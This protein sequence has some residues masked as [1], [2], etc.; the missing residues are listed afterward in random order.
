[1]DNIKIVL[2]VGCFVFYVLYLVTMSD[3]F[4]FY[5]LKPHPV[6][7]ILYIIKVSFYLGLV[8]Y[9]LLR[10]GSLIMWMGWKSII[11]VVVFYVCG[12]FVINKWVLMPSVKNILKMWVTNLIWL[13]FLLSWDVLPMG[14]VFK[15]VILVVFG[16]LYVIS[17]CC[18]W[19]DLNFYTSF[20]L[21]F[22]IICV[23]FWGVLL[24]YVLSWDVFILIC[25]GLSLR[26]RYLKNYSIDIF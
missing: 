10:E 11:L 19:R 12:I 15:N 3:R 23:G 8:Y 7:Y 17:V 21:L 24:Y 16:F 4:R 9:L 2:L 14:R 5:H 6:G 25:L 18:C 22:Q 26:N 20:L 1:M 13:Y